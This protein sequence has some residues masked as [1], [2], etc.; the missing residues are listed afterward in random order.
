M[1]IIIQ[2]WSNHT[3]SLYII[4]SIYSFVFSWVSSV[5]ESNV[6][7]SLLKIL[8]E[9][10]S[11]SPTLPKNILQI[12]LEQQ[13]HASFLNQ[14]MSWEKQ[15]KFPRKQVI[16]SNSHGFIL[17]GSD[18]FPMTKRVSTCF[19]PKR[20]FVQV[21]WWMAPLFHQ[22]KDQFRKTHEQLVGGFNPLGKISQIGSSPQLRVWIKNLSNYLKSYWD[23]LE[24][25]KNSLTLGRSGLISMLPPA[26]MTEY[27]IF[28]IFEIKYHLVGKETHRSKFQTFIL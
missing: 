3:L 21:D 20:S 25:T 26:N 9:L 17:R 4:Q 16:R 1:H 24:L 12:W 19:Y 5:S 15:R 2:K 18:L 28:R 23:H 11:S 27:S 13:K 8:E 6:S 14:P 10:N 22:Q 7:S